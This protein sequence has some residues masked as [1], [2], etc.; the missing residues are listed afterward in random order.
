[1]A[2]AAAIL[3]DLDAILG[4][5]SDAAAPAPAPL[6]PPARGARRRGRG[7]RAEPPP[8]VEESFSFMADYDGPLD[9]PPPGG[10][11]P[12]VLWA[13]VEAGDAIQARGAPLGPRPSP[14]PLHPVP[15]PSSAPPPHAP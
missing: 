8:A 12:Q 14:L 9:F 10:G 15:A 13:A 1:M 4:R 5:P 11:N 7:G 6:A 3:D 2:A